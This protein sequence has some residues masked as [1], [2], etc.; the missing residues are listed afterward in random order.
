MKKTIFWL[1]SVAILFI[2]GC[3]GGTSSSTVNSTLSTSVLL[4]LY[5]YPTEWQENDALTNLI[6]A[7]D[8]QFI[9]IINPSNG[10]GA[11][12]NTDYVDG[13]D[14]LYSKNTKI[15][16]YVYT[17]YGS[18]NKQDIYDDIDSYVSFYGTQKLSGIF[19]DEISLDNDANQTF[20]KDISS[21]ARSKNL[22]YIVLNPGTTISQS[23]IDEN[24]YDLIVT[25]ENPYSS[26]SNFHNPL[27]SS[28]ITKQALLVY[29][30]PELASYEDEIKKA[31]DMNFDYIY[32]TTDSDSNP[33][34]S[35]YNF[36]K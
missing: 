36:L 11:S 25:Y 8:G 5:S 23:I 15:V 6:D 28:Q 18:R 4:P 35:V 16:A 7:T 31:Q 24:Y 10:P 21:Y 14:Y 30:Y 29:A 17:S 2:Q 9:S 26:Y 22:N 3:G 1:L 34:D 27:V 20:V 33:W 32:L 19:F 13:I 12:Q